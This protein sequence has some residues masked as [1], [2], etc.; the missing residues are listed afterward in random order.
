V[1]ISIVFSRTTGGITFLMGD[2]GTADLN[3]NGAFTLGAVTR[4]VWRGLPRFIGNAP[5]GLTDL[6]VQP[7]PQQL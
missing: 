5:V 1:A 4:R 7:Q 3:V 2:G 6:I